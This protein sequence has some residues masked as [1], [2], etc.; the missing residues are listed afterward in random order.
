MTAAPY[1]AKGINF[2]SLVVEDAAQGLFRVHRRSL[3]DA[4]IF[5]LEKRRIFDRCWIYAGHDSEVPAPGDFRT[6][7]VAGRPV[8]LC[9]DDG[10]LVR[11]LLNSCRHRGAQVCTEA[12]GNARAFQCYYHGW[13]YNNRGALIGVPDPS[14]YSPAFDRAKLALRS[15]PRTDSYRGFIFVS[16]DP[17]VTS[18]R[19]YLAGAAEYLDIIADH[20]EAGMEVLPGS[21][22]YCIRS[23]WKL[24][25]ENAVDDFHVMTTHHRFLQY[26]QDSNQ[27]D[28][29]SPR[30]LVGV[31]RDLG[32]GHAVV[33]RKAPWARPIAKWSPIFGDERRAEFEHRQSEFEQRLGKERGY[34]LTQLNRNL[35]IFPNLMVNDIMGVIIRSCY[36]TRPDFME[37]DAWCLAPRGE[38]R[39][40]RKTRLENF[41][42]FL[43]PAGFANPD[44]AEALE[45]VQRALGT[46]GEVEWS[47]MSRGMAKSE[48]AAT[49]ELQLRAFWRQWRRLMSLPSGDELALSGLPAHAAV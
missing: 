10:G 21:H 25:M 17:K 40:D 39:D 33:E 37:V 29:E 1:V 12:K 11:V 35:I 42:S 28:P 26:L 7:S 9:R 4:D 38:R 14:S 22:S 31:A 34:R 13:T 43:G 46:S 47:D 16:F 19:D 6:R 36:P 41:I 23:N 2:D 45:S 44:D 27:L 32:N 49:D 18:L 30:G 3:A 20:C 8:I 48:P 24:L 15:P 5:A